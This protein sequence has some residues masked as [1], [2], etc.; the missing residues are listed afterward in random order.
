M[1][2]DRKCLICG[3]QTTRYGACKR[4]IEALRERDREQKLMERQKYEFARGK[5]VKKSS[6]GLTRDV[7]HT[8]EDCSRLDAAGGYRR[9][10]VQELDSLRECRTCSGEE[11]KKRPNGNEKRSCPKCGERV[12]NL[13]NHVRA[14]DGGE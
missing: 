7:Y 5:W 3:G 14:C 11:R 12:A 10:Y 6:G 1:T 8:S 9:A 2:R 13:P 4:T